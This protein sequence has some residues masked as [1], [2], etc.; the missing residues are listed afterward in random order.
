MSYL[1][2]NYIGVPRHGILVSH[3]FPV[4][5]TKETGEEPG[6]EVSLEGP[7]RVRPKRPHKYRRILQNIGFLVS[8]VFGAWEPDCQILMFMQFLG[9]LN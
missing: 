1:K 4:P 6:D 8:S 9:L 5:K 3:V 2:Q 7:I